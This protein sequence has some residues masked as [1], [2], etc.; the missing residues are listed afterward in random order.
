LGQHT[1]TIRVLDSHGKRAGFRN[2]RVL[3]EPPGIALAF[4][5]SPEANTSRKATP[6]TG[7]R[8]LASMERPSGL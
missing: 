4:L 1:I 7:L 8:R 6:T 5:S 2:I 3:F